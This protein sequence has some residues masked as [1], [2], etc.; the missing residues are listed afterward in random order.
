MLG[1][2]I[3]P[4]YGCAFSSI[5][6]LQVA[7]RS[8]GRRRPSRRCNAGLWEAAYQSTESFGWK[9][10]SNTAVVGRYRRHKRPKATPTR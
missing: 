9:I 8:S 6:E 5:I 1:R 3:Y 7:R 10:R 2:G 4:P